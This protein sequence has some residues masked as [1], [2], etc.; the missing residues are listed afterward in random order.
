MLLVA[1]LTLMTTRLMCDVDMTEEFELRRLTAGSP[2]DHHE[3]VAELDMDSVPVVEAVPM[4]CDESEC[5]RGRARANARHTMPVGTTNNEEFELHKRTLVEKGEWRRSQKVHEVTPADSA[6]LSAAP[7]FLR[8]FASAAD[9]ADR[10]EDAM[11][12]FV[13][14]NLQAS[15]ME[16]RTADAKDLKVGLFG[17][18]L[19]ARGH[20]KFFEWVREP[21]GYVLKV[22]REEGKP[23][24][25]RPVMLME[26]ILKVRCVPVAK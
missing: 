4:S 13:D 9:G 21:L 24:V 25:V 20:G 23:K 5:R 12:D 10:F 22:V 19:E 15:G 14:E 17:D 18:F 16:E 2:H 8:D 1:V 26:Y 3:V 11:L 6:E 7:D